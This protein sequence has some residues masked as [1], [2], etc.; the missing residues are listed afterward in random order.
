[1]EEGRAVNVNRDER[2]TRDYGSAA[3]CADGAGDGRFQALVRVG[4]HQLHVFEAAT[5]EITQEGRPEWLGIAWA[6]VQP[7]D[8]ALAVSACKSPRSGSH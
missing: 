2:R 1:M 5:D 8:L 3:G 4:D 7:D 6:G